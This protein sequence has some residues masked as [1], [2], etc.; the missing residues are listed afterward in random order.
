VTL[1]CPLY[2]QTPDPQNPNRL[3]NWS[4]PAGDVRLDGPTAKKF[5]TYR[6][7]Q[8]D[9]GRARRQQQ[10]IWAIRNQAMKIGVIPRI[11]ELWKAFSGA[12]ET[13]LGLLEVIGL[14]RFGLE[15]KPENV[16]GTALDHDVVKS[17]LTLGG[18][19]V[20]VIKDPPTLAARLEGIFA[21]KPL[22]ELGKNA[23][24]KCPPPPPGFAKPAATPGPA[25]T[26][27]SATVTPGP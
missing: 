26:L 22:A 2:E 10:L 14:A 1:D 8:S 19:A 6:Y 21:S 13:D 16:R 9:F 11:P 15:L 27:S 3:L 5:V 17:Y 25:V 18:A 7:L 23:S 20:L 24:G 12:F 4:L